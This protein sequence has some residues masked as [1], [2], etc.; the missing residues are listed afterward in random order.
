MCPRD[1]NIDIFIRKNTGYSW[2]IK[3]IFKLMY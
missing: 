1:N 3:Y 2:E